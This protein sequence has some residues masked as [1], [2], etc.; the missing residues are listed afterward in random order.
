[1]DH[2]RRFEAVAARRANGNA[3]VIP[4]TAPLRELFAAVVQTGHRHRYVDALPAKE[5]NQRPPPRKPV[6]TR[7][8]V[9]LGRRTFQP[10]P[11]PMFPTTGP[12]TPRR[13]D[14]RGGQP[15]PQS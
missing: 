7:S 9:V 15:E 6:P 13:V 2:S 4:F 5:Q 8:L 1:M 12:H 3:E 10:S 11:A 14:G